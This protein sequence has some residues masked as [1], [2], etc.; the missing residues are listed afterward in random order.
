MIQGLTV[1]IITPQNMRAV[2]TTDCVIQMP[3]DKAEAKL[4]WLDLH[5][6]FAN[7]VLAIAVI[8]RSDIPMISAAWHHSIFP[9]MDCNITDC[10]FNARSSARVRYSPIAPPSAM[11]LYLTQ[12]SGPDISL[13]TT[14][15]QIIG[16]PHTFCISVDN[17]SFYWHKMPAF[18]I[19]LPFAS[20]IRSFR[21]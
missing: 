8:D 9:L 14:T 2:M 19:F 12:T 6:D 10:I 18:K 13:A 4:L 21:R 7:N 16:L 3:T 1:G 20:P 15:G 17:L 11:E 5:T